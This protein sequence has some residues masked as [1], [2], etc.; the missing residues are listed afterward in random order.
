MLKEKGLSFDHCEYRY[1]TLQ[2]LVDLDN[3]DLLNESSDDE[4]GF[5]SDDS[6][7]KESPMVYADRFVDQDDE[8]ALIKWFAG[9]SIRKLDIYKR[10]VVVGTDPKSL[11]RLSRMKEVADVEDART[12]KFQSLSLGK[13]TRETSPAEHIPS[14]TDWA[15]SMAKAK[16]FA[17][18]FKKPSSPA[19]STPQAAGSSTT[20]VTMPNNK[21]G[22][23]EQQSDFEAQVM[24]L[25]QTEANR[26]VKSIPQF[27]GAG[28]DELRGRSSSINRLN[29]PSNSRD[30]S[31]KAGETFRA[32]IRHRKKNIVQIDIYPGDEIHVIKLVSGVTYYGEN[33]NSGKKGQFVMSAEDF[34]PGLMY[35]GAGDERPTSSG[36]NNSKISKSGI[37]TSDDGQRFVPR[38]VRPDGSVR[39]G[40][41]VRPGYTPPEDV[42]PWRPRK[43]DGFP[44]LTVGS[45]RNSAGSV[46]DVDSGSDS[47][48]TPKKNKSRWQEEP[49]AE[50]VLNEI[51]YEPTTTWYEKLKAKGGG[52]EHMY[53]GGPENAFTVLGWGK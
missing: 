11:S 34:D 25:I 24:E 41:P 53:V 42:E 51:K 50:K 3:L 39:R 7:D 37:Q 15:I 2:I 5:S 31:I 17:A 36:S 49:V 44:L 47:N 19:A 46:M 23:S 35:D 28:D 21:P 13:T 20:S 27:D 43:A 10:F 52:W 45:C 30:L 32:K 1:K 18:K 12:T 4:F 6:E 26:Q 22:Q 29:E 16:S 40:S 48:L 33:L 9:W 38:T 14:A 8:P